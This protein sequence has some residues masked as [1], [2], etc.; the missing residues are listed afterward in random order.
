MNDLD[1]LTQM[2]K[3]FPGIGERQAKRF[4]FFLLRKNPGFR[5]ELAT[6]IRTVRENVRQCPESF[7]FFYSE[8]PAQTLSPLMTD[9]NRD[10]SKLMVVEKDADLETIEKTGI[11]NGRY[12]VLGG[13][14]P[15]LNKEPERYVRLNE[16]SERVSK[17]DLSEIII[18]LSVTPQGEH[19]TNLV[20]KA[21]Q[22]V[23]EGLKIS[24]LGR[25]LSTGSE[26]EYIDADTLKS[27]L[28]NR[29]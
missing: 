9:P 2:F 23:S 26:L 11:F 24:T 27:A 5:D 12:F 22:D 29:S 17:Q 8:S 18:A 4:V 10:S 14:V 20:K 19:T 1:K 13:S 15:I 7:Q 28:Q 3:A 21:I 16:L 6:L 25:G